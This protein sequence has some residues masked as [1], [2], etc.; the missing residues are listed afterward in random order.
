V[1]L[2]QKK[3][4]YCPFPFNLLYLLYQGSRLTFPVV[5]LVLPTF[6]VGRTSIWFGCTFLFIYLFIFT[7]HGINQC[8]L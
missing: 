6:S 5:E 1:S 3:F 2:T 8:M 4:D 7:Y